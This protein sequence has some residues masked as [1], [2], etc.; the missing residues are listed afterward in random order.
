MVGHISKV[1][2]KILLICYVPITHAPYRAQDYSSKEKKKKKLHPG[3]IKHEHELQGQN[4][5]SV[6]ET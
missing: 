1:P 4:S 6:M 2:G 5:C 3:D